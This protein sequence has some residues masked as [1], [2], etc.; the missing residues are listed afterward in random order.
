MPTDPAAV[1]NVP[2][3]EI[4]TADGAPVESKDDYV[5]ATLTLK[6]GDN[7]LQASGKIRGRGNATWNFDKKPYK[8]KFDEKQGLCGFAANRSWTLLAEYSDKSLL[9]SAYMFIL[10]RYAGVPYNVNF[11]HIEVTLNGEYL[12][13]YVITDSIERNVGRIDIPAE[14][15][16][17]EDDNYWFKEPLSFTST[18]H[19]HYTF[20]YPDADD[21]EI[22]RVSES[23]FY[24]RDFIESMEAALY[25]D[26]FAD[27]QN[28][29][30]AYLDATSF[31]RWYLVNEL[32]CNYD[33]N[34]YYVLPSRETLL[35]MGPLWDAEWCL[36]LAARAE[37]GVG[38][39][40][41]PAT[42]PGDIDLWSREKYFKRLFQDPW[43][44]SLVQAEW[45]ALK[46][47]LTD[48]KAEI[49][50]VASYIA[51]AGERNFERWP[52]LDE[53]VSVGLVALG[54]WE[55]EVAYAAD[56]FERRCKWFDSFIANYENA[57]ATDGN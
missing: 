57:P 10:G 28:G 56:F 23:Y 18:R 53:Y 55:A 17:I 19:C 6:D 54:S 35:E 12:G 32:L 5:R 48:F 39:A 42:S 20:K 52:L 51:E 22:T 8:I 9:R 27:P 1:A 43:F 16:I 50:A 37:N 47:R 45:A 24:I 15:F 21:E 4:I 44:V 31:A 30:R 41:P 49:S 33:P 38:W 36:G 25:G 34:F 7:T 13:V 3:L 14:G 2:V 11:H 46:P 29:Y 40:S 26:D